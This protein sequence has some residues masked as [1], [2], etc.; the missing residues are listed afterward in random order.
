MLISPGSDGLPA[1][2]GISALVIA[3]PGQDTAVTV[4]NT[5]AG[6]CRAGMFT[7]LGICTGQAAWAMATSTGIIALLGASEVAL[8]ALKVL[9]SGYLL[10]LGARGIYKALRP[11]PEGME[12]TVSRPSSASL[13]PL[14][15]LGQGL[16]SN[17]A[18]PKMGA[19]FSSLLPQFSSSFSG[20]LSLGLIFCFLTLLWLSAYSLAVT[21]AASFLR[22]PHVRQAMEALT[23]TV[24]FALGIRLAMQGSQM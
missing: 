2:L 16:L 21:K 9:G 5:L 10:F 12:L 3:T 4:R 15:A 22:R 13:A 6:G 11:R 24:L 19:F 8:A 7:A 18:N 20:L 23:G 1:F 17:L 14:V